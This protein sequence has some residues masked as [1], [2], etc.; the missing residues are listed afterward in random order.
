MNDVRYL[1]QTAHLFSAYAIV[2]TAGVAWGHMAALVTFA[3]SMIVVTFKEFWYDANYEVPK[4]TA[5][6]N[7]LDF[8]FYGI[9]SGLG[10]LVA[11]FCT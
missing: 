10:L 7:W 1:S 5:L 9:G 8:I 11:F 4:Q 3:I 6:T 2:L